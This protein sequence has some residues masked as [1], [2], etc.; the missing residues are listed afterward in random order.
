MYIQNRRNCSKIKV[1]ST[2]QNLSDSISLKPAIA[3]FANTN[4]YASQKQSPIK[5]Q[6]GA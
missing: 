6:P 2:L 1:C 3:Y 5:P 4:L